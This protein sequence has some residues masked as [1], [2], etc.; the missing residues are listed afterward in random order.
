MKQLTFECWTQKSVK[1]IIT[2]KWRVRK[3]PGGTEKG[4]SNEAVCDNIRP[5]F[6]SFFIQTYL[7]GQNALDN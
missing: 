7:F 5:F 1:I 6:D 2:S 3:I 4:V